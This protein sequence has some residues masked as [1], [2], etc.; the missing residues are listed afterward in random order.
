MM[1]N[2]IKNEY[3]EL[4]HV[5]VKHGFSMNKQYSETWKLKFENWN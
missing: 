4:M 1:I 3:V 2:K 5:H